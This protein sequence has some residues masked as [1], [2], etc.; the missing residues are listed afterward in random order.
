MIKPSERFLDKDAIYIRLRQC[1]TLSC[2]A[3]LQVLKGA[4]CINDKG[5]GR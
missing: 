2:Q 1:L 5:D 4:L 3:L